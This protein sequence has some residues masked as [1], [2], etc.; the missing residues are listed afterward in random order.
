MLKKRAKETREAASKIYNDMQKEIGRREGGIIDRQEYVFK[1]IGMKHEAYFAGKL[2]GNNVRIQMERSTQFF[3]LL[4]PHVLDVYDE[5]NAD[6][7]QVKVFRHIQNFRQ[8]L[9]LLDALFSHIRGVQ[10]GILPS[11]DEISQLSTIVDNAKS[12]WLKCNIGTLQPKWHMVFSGHLIEQVRT[13]GGI[14][15]KNDDMIEKAH[16]PWKREK[17]RTWNVKQFQSQQLCQLKSIRK[18]SHHLIESKLNDFGIKRKRRFTNKESNPNT[19]SVAA[20]AQLKVT[21]AQKHLNFGVAA[22]DS[23]SSS[24]SSDSSVG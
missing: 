17:E 18:R 21:K 7:S 9:G 6:V 22:G 1:R 23:S 24:S 15:D 13:H 4:E 16:Q 8:L 10:T 11:D 14:G 12:W 19:K 20:S 2:N 3:D 5:E